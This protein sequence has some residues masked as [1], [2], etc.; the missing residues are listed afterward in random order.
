M[1]IY[2]SQDNSFYT[3]DGSPVSYQLWNNYLIKNPSYRI[4][5][6]P[7]SPIK[8]KA[9][10]PILK[11]LEDKGQYAQRKM[12]PT[13]STGSSCTVMLTYN[14]LEPDWIVIPCSEQIFGLVICQKLI[15]EIKLV[16]DGPFLSKLS[17]KT[18]QQNSFLFECKCILFKKY[19]IFTNFSKLEYENNENIVELNILQIKNMDILQEYFT[20]IQY[21]YGKPIEF[22]FSVHHTNAYLSYRPVHTQYFLKLTWIHIQNRDPISKYDGYMLFDTKPATIKKPSNVFQC[23]DG[24]Y[25]D[26]TSVCDGISDCKDGTDEKICHCN[27][28]WKIL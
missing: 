7:E 18:C 27:I 14:L 21:F 11:S 13:P 6:K 15:K 28:L 1:K 5:I 12:Q 20:N 17:T 10:Q 19:T 22:T 4:S 16:A 24:T 2:L 3:A 23:K 25:I 26:D 9:S 8:F